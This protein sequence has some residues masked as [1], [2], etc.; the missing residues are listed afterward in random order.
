VPILDQWVSLEIYIKLN[1][2]GQSDGRIAFWKDGVLAADWHNVR[3]RVADTVKL[4]E[5]QL[6][7]GGQGS[8]Q[9]N[10]KWYDNVVVATEYIGPVFTGA[11][12]T[13]PGPVLNLQIEQVAP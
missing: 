5:I 3:W 8:S 2:V 10:D 1:T 11:D 12:T 6:E 13:A 9:Q 7:N 4:D